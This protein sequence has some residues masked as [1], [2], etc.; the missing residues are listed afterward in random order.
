MHLFPLPIAVQ[1]GLGIATLVYFVPTSLA[2]GHQSGSV[3]LLS[4]AL[5]LM[6]ELRHLR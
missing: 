6:H 4:L 1:V 3:A 2:A 5:W